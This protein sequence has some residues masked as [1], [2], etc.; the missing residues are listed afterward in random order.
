MTAYRKPLEPEYL[1]RKR[2]LAR[3]VTL[4]SQRSAWLD[5][6]RE[7]AENTRPRSFRYLS[8]RASAGGKKNSKLING[9]PRRA[10]RTLAA[11]MMA[12]ITS[13]SRPWFRLTTSDQ[14]LKSNKAVK[15]WLEQLEETMREIFQK[16]NLYNALHQVYEDLGGIGTSAMYLET[17]EEDVLRAYNFP[18]GQYALANSARQAVDTVFREFEMSAGQLVEQFGKDKCSQPVKNCANEGRVD[19]YFKVLH[20]IEPNRDYQEGKLGPRGKKYASC[21]MELSAPQEQGFLRESGYHDFPVMVPRWET[22]GED[23]YGSSPGMDALGDCKALQLMEKRK[24]QAIDKIVTPPMKGP[25]SML[26]STISLLPGDF[27]AVEQG[28]SGTSFE[29]AITINPQAIPAINDAINVTS[30]AID[31]IFYADLWLSMQRIDTRM[32]ATEVNERREE[33]LLQLGPVTERLNDELLDPMMARAFFI[34]LEAGKL[35]PPPE[36]LQGR[37][38]QVEYIS[39]MAQAQ[40]LLGTTAVERISTFIGNLSVVFPEVKDKLNIDATVDVYGG[41]LGVSPT[42]V[43]TDEEV[44]AMREQRAQAQAKEQQMMQAQA[45]AGVAKDLSAADT[46]GDNALNTMLR[47]MGA[48]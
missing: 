16:S 24:A 26:T 33:K 35:P 14:A 9:K 25:V 12:G 15:K 30:Q 2:Y 34:A 23:V 20:V 21:W 10:L 44:A 41:M 48:Q 36:E 4:Q 17:D 29:P 1:R 32:T 7:V 8:D 28:G 6:W 39:I 43:R 38:L 31:E 42:I 27:N 37:D 19:E 11:G 40:K 3:W 45:A 5:H 13:P 18:V 22:T 47:G 46:G